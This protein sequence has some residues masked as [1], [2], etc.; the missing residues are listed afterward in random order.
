MATKHKC[1]NCGD[2]SFMGKRETVAI[3][4]DAPEGVLREKDVDYV[5]DLFQKSLD[6]MRRAHIEKLR[7]GLMIGMFEHLPRL[8]D[9]SD[10]FIL[11]E[12]SS[13]WCDFRFHELVWHR[14][15][16]FVKKVYFSAPPQFVRVTRRYWANLSALTQR[17]LKFQTNCSSD[18]GTTAT[19]HVGQSHKEHQG[20]CKVDTFVQRNSCCSPVITAE[21]T[22]APN[23]TS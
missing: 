9:G 13:S 20:N 22:R 19:S 12:L 16:I 2:T 8:P 5:L 17:V 3:I 11:V 15:K 7:D 4:M 6:I 1:W 21:E 18:T 23:G 10:S 14:L